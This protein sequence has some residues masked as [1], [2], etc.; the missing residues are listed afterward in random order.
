MQPTDRILEKFNQVSSV[1]RGTKYEEKI[2]Q[3]LID[4]GTARNF[5]SRV[6]T[7]GNL[8]IY[9]PASAGYE[10]KGSLVLQG[11]LDMV[12]Q[13]TLES[14]H[15]FMRDSIQVIRNGDWIKANGTTLGA[16]NGIA[17]ALMLA[18]I[19]DESVLHPPLE[20]LLTVEEELGIVGADGIDPSLLS[21]K[22]LINLDSESEGTF[23]VGC[24][25][26]GSV[27]VTLPVTWTT[28]TKDEVA[29]ELTVNGLQGGHSG[30]D[31][32]KNRA[33]AN[34]V[35]ARILD[36]I[37]RDV[38]IR[39]SSLQGGT[40]R[41]AIPRDAQAVFV[42]AEEQTDLCHQIFSTI[43][44]T[45]QAEYEY[46]E[47]NLSAK[48][49]DKNNEPVRSISKAE[50]VNGIRLLV[51]MPQGVAAMSAE[52]QGFVETS[53]NIGILELKEEGL[54]FIS[55]H[56]SSVNSRMEEIACQVE[57]L[58]WLA[59]ANT[60]RTKFFP[61]WQPNMNSPLLKKCIETYQAVIEEEPKVSLTHGGLECGIISERCGGLDTISL[62][63][64]IENPHS[65]DERLYVPSL[66]RVWDF[67]KTFLSQ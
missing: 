12:W 51:A 3:W 38:P 4:W 1:P 63:P 52:I 55:N 20:L 30:E 5:K 64:T 27:Y 61:S 58:A 46:A 66:S 33:N 60:E 48:L 53:N 15:D 40:A 36:V 54:F 26:G 13:K 47:P 8:V 6:D 67:L 49:T 2:R 23:T 28:Q 14:N 44:K 34:K 10:S 59:G 42:C 21:G 11:H 45:I 32:N 19:E 41:N 7:V 62:G 9:V 17:I 22:T 25:G 56:R 65:P 50:T 24:A 43:L 39:L 57:A 37:Q 35:I 29:F 18:L 16:D 31:I